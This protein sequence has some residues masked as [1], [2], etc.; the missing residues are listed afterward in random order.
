MKA[1]IATGVVGLGA[2]LGKMDI[3][4]IPRANGNSMA[5]KLTTDDRIWIDED[6]MEGQPTPDDPMDEIEI[7]EKLAEEVDFSFEVK[8]GELTQ[9][10]KNL[11]AEFI[12]NVKSK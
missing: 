5:V 10:A 6:E 1:W 11:L 9:H 7:P 12:T 4:V 3:L 2:G 8:G